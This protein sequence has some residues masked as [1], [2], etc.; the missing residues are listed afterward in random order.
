M[1]R[2]VSAKAAAQR[3]RRARMTEAERQA[4]AERNAA[5]QRARRARLREAEAAGGGERSAERDR[6]RHA[7]R[8]DRAAQQEQEREAERDADAQRHQERRAAL[9]EA[10]RQAEREA[11]A[12]QHQEQRAAARDRPPSFAARRPEDVLS[13]AQEVAPDDVGAMNRPCAACGALRWPGERVTLCCSGG[14]VRLDPLPAPP[15]VLRRLWTD[16]TV[17]ARTFRRHGRHLNSA[18][19]LSSLS[20]REVP[21]PAGTGGYAPCVVVQGRMY[22]RLGPMEPNDGQPPSF[23]QIYISDPRAEDPDAEAATRLGHVRLPAATSAAAQDRLLDLLRRLQ[24]L[25]RRCNPW[26]QDFIM[27]AEILAQEVEQRRLVISASARPAGQH[28]RRYN[29]AEGLQE[30]AVLIGDEPG[31]HDLVLR[32]RTEREAAALQVIDETHRACD[33]LH[34]VLLFPWGTDGWHPTIQQVPQPARQRQRTVTAL[35]YYAYRLQ[36]R[37]AEDD[38]LHRACRLLQEFMCMAFA[39]V[40][41]LRLRFIATHQRDIRADLYQNIQDAVAADAELGQPDQRGAG[42]DGANRP[43]PIIGR[44]IVLPATFVGGPRHMQQR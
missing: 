8:A 29:V 18:L 31:P 15:D 2:G 39:K 33:P 7:E 13:G 41:S 25:L 40:E 19:A 5:Q 42:G 32:L 3:R 35:Q 11:N 20:A 14:K 28:E 43:P 23:A 38:S 16:D 37:P 4:E 22:H 12:R 44:R 26:V 17:E 10:E 1:P 6:Q 30:V 9:E 34:F 21:P 36:V 24:E 27:A